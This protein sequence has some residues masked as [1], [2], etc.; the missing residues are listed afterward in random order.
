MVKISKAG[1]LVYD[2]L[3]GDEALSKAVYRYTTIRIYSRTQSRNS[4]P[5]DGGA[6]DEAK[7]S[8]HV[9]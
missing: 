4:S 7:S 1:N 8:G 3:M 2:S 9:K 6:N 5:K